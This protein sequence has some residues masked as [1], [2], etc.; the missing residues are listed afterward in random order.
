MSSGATG[1]SQA[2]GWWKLVQCTLES[3]VC[4]PPWQYVPHSEEVIMGGLSAGGFSCC[5]FIV[6]LFFFLLFALFICGH[7][8]WVACLSRTSQFTCLFQTELGS[9]VSLHEVFASF[10][11]T[12]STGSSLLTLKSLVH[13]NWF[14]LPGTTTR[15]VDPKICSRTG[16]E[17]IFGWGWI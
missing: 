8:P 10:A 1:S 7:V 11:L 4:V 12:Q 3:S 6:R 13:N 9:F 16:N 15:V 14:H 2:T 5:G 17:D